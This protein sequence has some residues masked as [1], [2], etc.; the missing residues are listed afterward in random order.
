MQEKIT[1]QKLADELS[2]SY[3][4]NRRGAKLLVEKLFDIIANALKEGKAVKL[5]EIGVLKKV[6]KTERKARN[7]KTG[8][9][10]IIPAHYTIRFKISKAFKEKLNEEEIN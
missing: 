3:P 1:M 10:I 8:E 5:G 9:R 2:K 7:P 4:I 6:L